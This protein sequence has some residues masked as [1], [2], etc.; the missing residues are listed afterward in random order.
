L[1]ASDVAARV[2]LS[3]TPEAYLA[4][5]ATRPESAYEALLAV[6]RT[7]WSPGE[8]VR[9]YR[10]R[11]GKS[12]W[13]PEESEE[14]SAGQGWESRE[15]KEKVHTEAV[16]AHHD[17]IANRRDY[18]MEHYMRA[19]FTSYATRLRK[20]YAPDDFERLFRTDEQPGLFD[21]PIEQ[22]QPNWIRCQH[23]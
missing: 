12:V 3:K 2:R 7:K 8:R 14:A 20:A 18:D 16:P 23:V 5:K 19:L 9:F 6:G 11:G 21:Q 10:A 15:G 17:D 22:I 13:I 1:T 4:S